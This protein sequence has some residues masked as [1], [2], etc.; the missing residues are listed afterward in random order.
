MGF[1]GYLK[2]KLVQFDDVDEIVN[3]IV[4]YLFIYSDEFLKWNINNINILNNTE[5]NI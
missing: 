1:M 3:L 2:R 5:S 4:G